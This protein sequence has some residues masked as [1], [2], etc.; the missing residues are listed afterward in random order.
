MPLWVIEYFGK[1]FLSF[2]LVV[3][4]LYA[5]L[6]VIM[7]A[8]SPQEQLESER[9]FLNR[10]L[11]IARDTEALLPSE[12]I[13]VLQQRNPSDDQHCA[14]FRIPAEKID[15]LK[16]A[17]LQK[18]HGLTD[19]EVIDD[20]AAVLAEGAFRDDA[21]APDWWKPRTTPDTDYL[22]IENH[23]HDRWWIA[24][25]RESGDVYLAYHRLDW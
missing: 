22:L 19:T 13:Q 21:D 9:A 11:P 18:Y 3:G 25:S 7:P 6:C 23:V 24:L 14:L 20:D 1:L 8:P 2:A 4:G 15:A 10:L 17:I 12:Q 5:G 16:L